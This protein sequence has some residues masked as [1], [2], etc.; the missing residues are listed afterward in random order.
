MD[1]DK[2]DITITLPFDVA[3]AALSA[4]EASKDRVDPERTE[5][6][7]KLYDAQRIFIQEMEVD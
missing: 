1:S 6:R 5:Y 7:Q 2:K 3:V 4:I